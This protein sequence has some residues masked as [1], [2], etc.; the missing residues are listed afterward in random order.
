MYFNV[1]LDDRKFTKKP[2]SSEVPA[3][4]HNLKLAITDIPS[5]A[6]ALE[7]GQTFRAAV[8][9][10]DL[11]FLSQQVFALD[12]DGVPIDSMLAIAKETGIYPAIIYHTFSQPAGEPVT[13]FRMVFVS[14]HPITDR[15]VRDAI[16]QKLMQMYANYCDPRCKDTSRM[17]YGG[18]T[19]CYEE[20]YV[21]DFETLWDI[22]QA[23]D[24][25]DKTKK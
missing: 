15:G 9:G 2:T 12:F 6:N 7:Q 20:S 14:D 17:F 4:Y 10:K 18:K 8:V 13:R 24:T 11:S 22:K 16:M 23:V 21:Y 3:I 5:F 19:S 1:Q 25:A